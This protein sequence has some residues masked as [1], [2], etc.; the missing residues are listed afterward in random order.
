MIFA[1]F[2]NRGPRIVIPMIHVCSEHDYSHKSDECKPLQAKLHMA[3]VHR[4]Y[5]GSAVF[6]AKS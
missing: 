3:T 4:R 6:V 2:L 1:L 5:P